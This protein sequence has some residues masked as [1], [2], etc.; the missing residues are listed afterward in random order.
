MRGHAVIPS[1]LRFGKFLVRLSHAGQEQTCRKCNCQGHFTNDCL[2]TFCFN[3][4][5]LGPKAKS[6]PS[7]ELCC[8]C[9]HH[10]YWAK[11]CPHSWY[12]QPSHPDLRPVCSPPRWEAAAA[13]AWR[14]R[15]NGHGYTGWPAASYFWCPPVPEI[16]LLRILLLLRTPPLLNQ[17]ILKF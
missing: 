10:S 5:E 4:E 13:S 16:P 17:L 8:I 2:N 11:Y 7:L 1:C 6:C 12:H 14:A 3:C 9:K 15:A